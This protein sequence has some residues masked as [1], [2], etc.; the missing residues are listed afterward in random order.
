MDNNIKTPPHFWKQLALTFLL[1]SSIP[2]AGAL[3]EEFGIIE[4]APTEIN[5]PQQP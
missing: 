1:A 5:K 4:P 2:V 3:M